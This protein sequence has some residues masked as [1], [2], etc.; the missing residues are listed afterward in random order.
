[1]EIGLANE[2][3]GISYH[4]LLEKI[5][6]KFDTLNIGAEKTFLSWFLENFSSE[7][8]KTK[9]KYI[10]AYH[11]YYMA[12]KHQSDAATGHQQDE[13][14]EIRTL[15]SKK[16]WLDG[17]A[18]KQYVDY[19]ELVEART[20]SK[21][22]IG[23]AI[24]AILITGFISFLEYNK[25]EPIIPQQPYDV[26]VIENNPKVQELEKEVKELTSELHKAEMLISSFESEK[27]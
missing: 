19:L 17:T 8:G 23:I 14:N 13:I 24:V 12:D 7:D 18:S 20:S 15:L 25:P 5:E 3:E 21:K 1:M 10:L 27:K 26:K 11:I 22:A 4:D 6:A 9:N 2:K 16:Y